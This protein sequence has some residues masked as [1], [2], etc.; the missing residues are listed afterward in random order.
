MMESMFLALM[1]TCLNPTV[2]LAAQTQLI[3][4]H[5][6]IVALVGDDVLLPCHLEP[7]VSATYETVV[8]S[9]AALEPKYVHH[10]DGRLLFEKQDPSYFLRTRLF[11]DELQRGNVSMKISKV[12]LSDAGTYKCSLPAMKKEAEVELIVGTSKR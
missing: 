10:K 3:G 12:E 6:P 4:S 9:K 2:L 7:A 11:M 5:Q 1:F 8:W